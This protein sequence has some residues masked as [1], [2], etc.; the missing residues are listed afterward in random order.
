MHVIFICSIYLSIRVTQEERQTGAVSLDIY[1]Y[2]LNSVSSRI[3]V[4]LIVLLAVMMQ[5][6]KAISDYWLAV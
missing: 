4:P 6:C 5:A 1:V 2:Y 3:L